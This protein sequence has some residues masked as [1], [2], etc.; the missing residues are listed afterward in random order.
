MNI[1]DGSNIDKL[2]IDENS[3]S[4]I[5]KDGA[6]DN[7]PGNF[8]TL[9]DEIKSEPE[10]STLKLTKNY[11]FNSTTDDDYKSG[12]VID[13]SITIDGNGNTLSG[14]SLARIFYV[15]A[16]NVTLKNITFSNGYLNGTTAYGG[17]IYWNGDNGNVENCTFSS[18]NVDNVLSG[19]IFWQGS[20]GSI[21][22]ST[23][24]DN[25][26]KSGG[27]VTWNGTS[28]KITDSSFTKNIATIASG[29]AVEWYGKNGYLNNCNF[30]ENTG[31]LM[32][33]ALYA[34]STYINVSNCNFNSNKVATFVGGG[35]V[36]LINVSG[37]F[38]N[39]TFKN[40]YIFNALFSNFGKAGALYWVCEGEYNGN[41]VNCTFNGN[42]A[43]TG[44]SIYANTTLNII[45]STFSDSS[46][47]NTIYSTGKLFLENN[48]LNNNNQI[49][50]SGTVTSKAN[51]SILT[52]TTVIDEN[53]TI[54]I[55]GSIVD[56]N[57]N[58]IILSSLDLIIN[59]EKI[60]T[61]I[62]SNGIFYANYT[63]KKAG[64]YTITV[65]SAKISNANLSASTFYT[66]GIADI[67]IE[68]KDAIYQ[69][70]TIII[71]SDADG[72]YNISIDNTNTTITLTNNTASKTIT[73]LNIGNHTL[74]ARFNGNDIFYANSESIT[75]TVTSSIKSE[76]MKR[77]YNSG[78]DF[79]AVFY[80]NTG[81]LLN[82]TQIQF[83]IDSTVYNTTTDSNG[84][85]T[86]NIKLSPG[87][88]TVTSINTLTGE[89]TNNTLTIVKS[90][91]KN[92][93]V[94][95]YYLD[96]SYFKILIYGA[97]GAIAGAGEKVIFKINSKTYTRTTNSAGYAVLNM[98]INT[99]VPKTYEITATY[100]GLT[101]SN[102]V[103]VKQIITAKKTTNVKKSAKKL[104]IKITLKGKSVY[105]NKVIKIK[106]KNKTYKIK[107]NK[108]G[109][110][111]FKITKKV[112]KTLKKGKKYTYT[113]TFN[114]DTLKRYI[115][116]K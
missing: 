81:K 87:S 76:D 13:K 54:A 53:E 59:N 56:D 34:Y 9:A 102:T 90:I 89:E 48:T 69:S 46:N 55:N 113:I 112:I 83:K 19:A 24:K 25:K 99:L 72:T 20:N 41:I 39:T 62:D 61:E 21:T 31:N 14:N 5:I 80:D 100:N 1:E 64:K 23:F 77:G 94:N 97:D 71:T 2:N 57:N 101:V 65:D 32:G 38:K 11:T 116:V 47:S 36:Y 111:T 103:K 63:S 16:S 29:G 50:V 7:T 27:A 17:A 79:T 8:S 42:S 22:Q 70:A 10:G 74:T 33:G 58:P 3:D 4:Q 49:Y 108:K 40:N 73:G 6:T 95:M 68:V 15:N 85:A 75:F 30:T 52:N 26:A 45:N 44:K 86:L 60:E 106:F 96:G 12:I 93:N 109:V 88:Y 92:T 35:A 18:N 115:N 91:Q 51:I 67:N 104:N 110:A 66:K 43:Q 37:N 107:T 98:N 105:K 84:I 82:L 78:T 114:K 28:G